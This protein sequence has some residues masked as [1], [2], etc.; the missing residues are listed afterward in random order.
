VSGAPLAN[1]LALDLGEIHFL[2]KAGLLETVKAARSTLL[3]VVLRGI[4]LGAD[5]DAIEHAPRS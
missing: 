4:A 1:D 5:V 2:V 3:L